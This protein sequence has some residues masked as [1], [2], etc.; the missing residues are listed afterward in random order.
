MSEYMSIFC[1]R[2]KCLNIFQL[3]GGHSS[4]NQC[5]FW[6][7]VINWSWPIAF[8]SHDWYFCKSTNILTRRHTGSQ[9]PLARW[10]HRLSGQLVITRGPFFALLPASLT[11]APWLC[12]A[13][14]RPNFDLYLVFVVYVQGIDY[15]HHPGID[16]VPWSCHLLLRFCG[17]FR[18]D[19]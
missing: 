9:G 6:E 5:C 7:K 4:H 18:A 8:P 16:S 11:G 3:M 12:L 1:V 14:C 13:L 15:L 2:K 10:F 19:C 17:G